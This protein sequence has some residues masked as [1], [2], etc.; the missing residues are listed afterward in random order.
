MP[1]AQ[2]MESRMTPSSKPTFAV[3]N[4]PV[5]RIATARAEKTRPALTMAGKTSLSTVTG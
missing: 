4:R 5:I 3:M 1:M 2:A